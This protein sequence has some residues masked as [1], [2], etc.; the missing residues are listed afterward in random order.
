MKRSQKKREGTRGVKV[1]VE[2]RRIERV[3]QRVQE[4]QG[5]VASKEANVVHES[6][7]GGEE[8]SRG[9]GAVHRKELA[10]Q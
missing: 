3:D 8:G 6:D 4:S 9:R 5:R 7:E 2:M 10:T 1:T